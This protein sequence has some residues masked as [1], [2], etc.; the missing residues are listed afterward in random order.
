MDPVL[1]MV[2]LIA[3]IIILGALGEY[4]F[5]RTSIP[6]MVWLVA[7]GIVAGPILDVISPGMLQ[8][9]MPFFGAIALISILAGGGLKLRI[10][11]VTE[12]A[13]RAITLGLVSFVFALIG[14]CLF[15]F[16]TI[17]IGLVK[18]CGLL[19]W[20]TIGAIMGG[21][22]SLVV[23]PAMSGKTVDPRVAR[24]LELES[25]VTDAVCMVVALS[26]IDLI[27]KGTFS[28]DYP[29]YAIAKAVLVAIIFGVIG[30]IAVSP[31]LAI[32]RGRD[33]AY[34]VFLAGFLIIYGC[35]NLA[36][37]N[38]ALGVLVSA[39]LIGNA[40]EVLKKLRITRFKRSSYQYRP[41]DLVIHDHIS[42]FIKSFFFFMI[43]LMF[44][45][46]PRLILLGAAFAV[47]LLIFRWPAVKLSLWGAGMSR[48]QHSL[49]VVAI[50]RGM[51]AGVLSMVPMQR[52]MANA[53]NLIPGVFAGIIFTILLFTVGF[54]LV[55]RSAKTHNQKWPGPKVG[56]S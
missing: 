45:T 50:P 52:G 9:V 38:G 25:C 20:I 33:H 34:T 53:E 28:L 40:S 16:V 3:F 18:P 4:I 26:A 31:L 12:A 47:M 35:I 30:A 39:L 23:I 56:S 54:A 21:T 10:A 37:G 8:P 27:V 6:D 7:A 51:A 13:P 19:S 44:P 48:S 2:F 43:G 42:F 1:Q 36:G 5:E 41:S 17:K 15:F 22:S 49:A 14:T 11:E 29:L 24:L 46:S 32:L 55:Q